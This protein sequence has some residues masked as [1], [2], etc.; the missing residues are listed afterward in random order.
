MNKDA[1]AARQAGPPN[2]G[3]V[4]SLRELNRASLARQLLLGRA[5]LGVL[6]ALGRLV[7][8]QAQ[9]ARAPFVGLWARLAD[10]RPAEL[11]EAILARQVVRA[12]LVRGTLH[13]LRA[14][15]FRAIRAS[16][17]GESTITLPGGRR[18]TLDELEPVLA[19]AR[20][21]FDQPTD[22]D[23]LRERIAA[24]GYDDVR[25]LAY[26]ARLLL[27]L[28]QASS[29]GPY[30]FE[31]GGP[32]VLASAWLG[33]DRDV[34]PQ[35]RLGEL[36]R[37]YLAAWGPATPADFAA[38]S[39]LKGTAELFAALGDDL[40]V[41]ADERGRRLYD[42]PQAPRPAANVPAPPRL[43]PD[44]DAVMLGWQDRTRVISA[45]HRQRLA[46]PNLQIPPVVLVDG[47][48]AGTWKLARTRRTAT[49]S[50]TPFAP[51]AAADAQAVEAEAAAL[52]ATFEPD[53]SGLVRFV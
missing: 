35:V 10:F 40:V 17:R 18:W 30:G 12:T 24:A 21:Q 47:F 36:V 4:L 8:L 44:F 52:L 20:A 46:T 27:P 11:R 28:V 23:A 13:L 22:F 5:R 6:E 15:D 9:L 39:G 48:V 53:A 25:A 16:I 32:F 1:G 29:D 42:L 33:A 50:I 38:W 34:D 37:R 31:A 49:I 19:L 7:A 26:A 45:E 14:D 51:L 3:P 41:L 43:L 2:A